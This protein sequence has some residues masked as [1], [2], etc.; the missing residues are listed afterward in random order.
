MKATLEFNLPEESNQHLVA[1]RSMDL[2]IEMQ[3]AWEQVRS[4]LKHGHSF[5]TPDEAL[6]AVK[7]RLHDGLL[8]S[9]GE[10]A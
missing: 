1:V 4:W 7:T 8:I 5:K 10:D 9:L 2:A 6:E 3:G